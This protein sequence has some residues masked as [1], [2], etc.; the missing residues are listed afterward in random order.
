MHRTRVRLAVISTIADRHNRP[1][2]CNRQT[3][4]LESQ[5]L[6]PQSLVSAT[7]PLE[8]TIEDC[9]PMLRSLV[10]R[11]FLLALIVAL[12]VAGGCTL[13]PAGGGKKRIVFLTN[14]SDPFWD[15]CRSGLEE[16]A[17]KFEI[18]KAGYAVA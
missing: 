16:G 17:R 6:P 11:P 8:P 14:G 9:S 5:T 15:A 4:K 1:V 7:R 2:G 3:A 10:R 18:D 12:A 13:K